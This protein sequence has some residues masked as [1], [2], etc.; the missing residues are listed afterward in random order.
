M[1]NLVNAILALEC[2]CAARDRIGQIRAD[3]AGILPGTQVIERG[4]PALARA[5]MRNRAKKQAEGDLAKAKAAGEAHVER[6]RGHRRQMKDEQESM[7]A[8]LVPL[9][10][11]GCAVWIGILVFNNVRQRREEIGILRAIGIRSFQILF[12]F[13]GKAFLVGI[14]GAGLGYLA[15]FTVGMLWSGLPLTVDSTAVLFSL[16]ALLFAI[17][18]APLLSGVASWIPAMSAARQDPAIVLQQ[19]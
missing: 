6:E 7:A 19:N 4:P 17:V 8:I 3:L 14:V 10:V 1:Q 16:Q 13:L 18:M 9:V 11:A 5:E 2:N 15:G 12:I